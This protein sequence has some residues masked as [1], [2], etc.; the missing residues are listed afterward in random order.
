MESAVCTAIVVIVV[1]VLLLR[2]H[3]SDKTLYRVYRDTCPACVRSK[4]AWN[5]MKLYCDVVGLRYV[6]IDSDRVK[7]NVPHVPFVWLESADGS[8]KIYSGNNSTSSLVSFLY[9]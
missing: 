7:V 2:Y 9:Y 5:R 1:V 3:F 6:E 8:K 4:P